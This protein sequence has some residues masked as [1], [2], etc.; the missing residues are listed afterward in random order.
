MSAAPKQCRT[1]KNKGTVLR[2]RVSLISDGDHVDELY[3][4]TL[5][6]SS[7]FSCTSPLQVEMAI[8]SLLLH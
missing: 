2:H 6:G 8:V 3:E 4:I 5:F 7:L 1:W